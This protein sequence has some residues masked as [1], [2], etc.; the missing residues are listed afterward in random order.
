MSLVIPFLA[1]DMF[2][3]Y[4]GHAQWYII[5]NNAQFIAVRHWLCVW[6]SFWFLNKDIYI[7]IFIFKLIHNE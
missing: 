5:E 4:T 1:V 7:Y 6:G 2:P 3:L